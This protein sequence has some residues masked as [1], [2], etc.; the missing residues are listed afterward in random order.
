MTVKSG[1]EPVPSTSEI[2]AILWLELA[3]GATRD[4]LVERLAQAHL[5]D[6]GR[7]AD[8]VDSFLA[9]LRDQEQ[10]EA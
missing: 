8:D 5:V 4:A 3:D 9:K 2:G 6:A 7:A 10:P 1:P